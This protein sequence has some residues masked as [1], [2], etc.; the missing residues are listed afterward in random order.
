MKNRDILS[1]VFI[2]LIKRLDAILVI[3][4]FINKVII[5][6]EFF[7]SA[8]LETN[9]INILDYNYLIFIDLLLIM[10]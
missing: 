10:K 6:A 3:Y 4:N 9:L 5:L 8:P 7:F 2:F 1:S